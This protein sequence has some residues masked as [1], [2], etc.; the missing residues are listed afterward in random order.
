[1]KGDAEATGGLLRDRDQPGGTPPQGAA[2]E[3]A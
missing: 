2:V 1:V 3:A